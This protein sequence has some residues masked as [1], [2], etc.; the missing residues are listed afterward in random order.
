MLSFAQVAVNPEGKPVAE[1]IPVAPNVVCMTGVSNAFTHCSV[2]KE[3][4]LA[5]LTNVTVIFPVAF[6]IPQPPVKGIV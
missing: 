5:L 2:V 4:E 3:A 1:P 6:T